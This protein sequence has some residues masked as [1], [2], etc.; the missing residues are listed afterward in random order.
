MV[1]VHFPA[2]FLFVHTWPRRW[3]LISKSKSLIPIPQPSP[4][5]RYRCSGTTDPP[6]TLPPPPE[7]R[8]EEHTSELQSQFHLVCRLL[9]EKKKR[10]NSSHSS[11]SYAVLCLKKKKIK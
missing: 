8:S 10:L 9:H 1:C 2:C 6:C 3:P 5:P 7:M 11:I 4:G